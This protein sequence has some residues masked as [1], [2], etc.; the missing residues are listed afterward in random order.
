V[1]LLTS[2]HSKLRQKFSKLTVFYRVLIGNSVVIILGAMGGTWITRQFAMVGNLRLIMLFSSLG[3]ALSLLVNFYILKSALRPMQELRK[4]VE[5]VKV[6]QNIPAEPLLMYTDPDIHR[7]VQAIQ[8]IFKRLEDRTKQL[9]ALSERSINVQEEER[10]RIA[11]GLHDDT[12]QAISS[13][14]IQLERLENQ[15]SID[16][17]KAQKSIAE[18]RYLAIRILDDLRKNIWDLRPSIL[19]DL[20]LV[21]A[22][23]WYA[24][25]CLEE[26]G[27]MVNYD[28]PNENMR[29]ESHL[30]TL[31]FRISQEAFT[32]ILRHANAGTVTIRLWNKNGQ[33]CLEIEDDGR[34]FNVQE[35]SGLAV[36]RKQL[37]LLG[38]EERI[39]LVGGESTI[40][41]TPG[42]GTLIQV[43]VP[44][45]S[46]R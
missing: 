31:L 5:Q 39:S 15:D 18:A 45:L 42:K 19:D 6:G 40:I 44:I 21:P 8:S 36:S 10:K 46:L 30:E 16:W 32:N 2:L 13:L 29:L 24:H 22:I 11:R 4:I 12:A 1:K 37:G 27:V 34:G 7:L 28:I 17:V 43:L 38:I 14:I 35:I 33:I 20:G 9:Q 23:H 26:A 25:T 41:S 3:I